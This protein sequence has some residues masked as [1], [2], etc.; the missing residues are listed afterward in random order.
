M[1]VVILGV[2]CNQCGKAISL[3]EAPA[4]GS[5][6]NGYRCFDCQVAHRQHVQAANAR[7]A[8]NYLKYG[9]HK[10][11]ECNRGLDE[12]EIFTGKRSLFHHYKDGIEQMLCKLCS[13][14][15]EIKNRRLYAGTK[16]AK[17]KNLH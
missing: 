6:E 5:R 10:C 8:E 16:Y 2:P 11:E 14:Q 17:I 3:A 1:P 7:L 9:T 13:D 15:Y 12:I 4:C